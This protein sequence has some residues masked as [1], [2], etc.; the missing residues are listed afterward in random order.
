MKA[1]ANFFLQ[2][3]HWQIFLLLFALPTIA[4]IAAMGFIPATIRSWKDIG[5]GGFVYLGLLVLD[6]FCFL[7]WLW[8]M[9]SFLNSIQNPTLKLKPWFFRLA[10]IY[11][12]AYGFVFFAVFLS[13]GLGPAAE[14]VILPLHLFAMFCMFY[15]LYFVAKSLV[16]I[17]KG[18]E[19]VFGDYAK[20]LILL[21]LYPIGVWFIQPR[22]N[23]LYAEIRNAQPQHRAATE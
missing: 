15:V 11:P 17:N 1:V 6:T 20:S 10:L 13:P 2:A 16:M 9:G 23:Q 7:A 22:I 19:V 14:K 18:K 21:C 12:P 8:V 4:D 3:K 5:Q